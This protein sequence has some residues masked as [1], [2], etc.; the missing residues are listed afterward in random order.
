MSSVHPFPPHELVRR[1][2]PGSLSD[3]AEAVF[4]VVEVEVA[5]VGVGGCFLHERLRPV[6]EVVLSSF[7]SAGLVPAVDLQ[8]LELIFVAVAVDVV[9]AAIAAAD[10]VAAGDPRAHVVVVAEE[11]L[12]NQGSAEMM[13]LDV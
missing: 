5:A 8:V 7:L 2:V 11:V 1:H 9:A 3:A 13:F 10:V 6:D 12:V 4:V